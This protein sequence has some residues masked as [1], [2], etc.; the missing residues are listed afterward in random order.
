M[1]FGRQTIRVLRLSHKKIGSESFLKGEARESA[2]QRFLTAEGN[3]IGAWYLSVLVL[4]LNLRQREGC[5]TRYV[6]RMYTGLYKGN[7]ALS[8]SGYAH[9]SVGWRCGSKPDW[10]K[11][12]FSSGYALVMTGFFLPCPS[13]GGGGVRVPEEGA[14]SW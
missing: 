14:D 9:L 2:S 12:P 1:Y 13:I 11:P 3:L 10:R 8:F 4:G 5:I 7:A 6:Y